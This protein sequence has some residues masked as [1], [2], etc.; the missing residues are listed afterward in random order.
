MVFDGPPQPLNEDVVL[1][2][3]TA[4]HADRYAVVFECLGEIVAGKLC[5]LV[6]VEDFRRTI[7]AQSVIK[8]MDTEIRLKGI[9]N[10]PG[11][12]SAAIPVHDNDKIHK[13]T[14]HRNIGDVTGPNLVDVIDRQISEQIRENLMFRM[15]SAGVGFRVN[16][17]Y[18]H[19]SH[20]ALDPFAVDLTALPAEMSRHRPAAV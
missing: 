13:P 16:R 5:P 8:R 7:A 9:G 11:Q 6:R 10:A 12:D 3:T 14:G 15:G 1:A 20:Q 17:L 19:Q 18:A 2:S 4:V